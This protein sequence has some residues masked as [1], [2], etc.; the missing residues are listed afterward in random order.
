MWDA[1]IAE[2]E[3]TSMGTVARLNCVNYLCIGAKI[4]MRGS[5]L[6]VIIINDK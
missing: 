3:K 4:L 6:C 5:Q 1:C 2:D